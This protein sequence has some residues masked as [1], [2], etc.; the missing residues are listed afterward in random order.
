[1]SILDAIKAAVGG[2]GSMWAAAGGAALVG[3]LAA[4]GW[5][6]HHSGYEAGRAQALLE[7]QAAA[8]KLSEQYRAQEAAVQ[9]TVEANYA[10]YRGQILATQAAA[11]GRYADAVAGLRR[12]IDELR[13]RRAAPNPQPASRTDAAAGPDILTVIGECTGR[14]DQ[15]VRYAAGLAD[16]VNG[17]QGY[18]RAMGAG[19]K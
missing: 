9:Q 5:W 19:M 3:S 12:Q 8:Q 6:L 17:L 4:G 14:Y 10:K 16:Q 13:T 11:D 7:A 15:V 1:M 2:T 18:V